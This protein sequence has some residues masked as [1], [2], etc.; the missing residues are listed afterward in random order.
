QL[1]ELFTLCDEEAQRTAFIDNLLTAVDPEVAGPT[2]VVITLRADFYPHCAAYP[3]LREALARNQEY[4]GPMNTSELRRAIEEPALRGGWKFQSGLVDLMLRDVR[5][6]PGALPLLSHALLETWKRRSRRT[7]TLRGYAEAG[8]VRRAIARSAEQVYHQELSEEQRGIAR[9]VFLRLTELGEGTEDTRRRVTRTELIPDLGQNG[10]TEGVLATLAEA[11]L[12]TLSEEHVEVAH[13]ALIREWPRLREWLDEDR[14]GLRIHR[15]L[16]E[17]AQAWEA[18]GRDPGELYRGSRLAQVSEWAEKQKEELNPLERSFLDASKDESDRREKEREARRRRTIAG[19]AAGMVI[20]L[21][22]ALLAGLQWQR[23]EVEE[24]E[25][26]QQASILLA[27]QA[28]T[29]LENGY[30]DRAV[31]LALEALENYPYTPQA[32]KALGQAVSYNRALQHYSGH[33]S[34]VTS[35]A[36]SPDGTRIAS[37]STDNTVHIWDASTGEDLLVIDLPQ[38]ITGNIFDMALTVKWSPDGE[39]LLIVTGDRFTLGSQDFDI[40]LWDATSGEQIMSFEIANRAEPEAG[41]GIPT[42]FG[43]FTTAAAAD[44]APLSGRLATLGG[45]N[46]T[47]VWDA[48]LQ[49]QEL[50]LVGHEN[51]VNGVDWSP[52]EQRLATASEDGTV[53]IW[54]SQ[55]GVE[56]TLLTGHEGAVNAVVWSPDGTQLGTGG[57]DGTVLFWDAETGKLLQN[58]ESTGGIV[59]SLAWSMD[60]SHLAIGTDDAFIRIWDVASGMVVTEFRGHSAFVSHVAWSPIGDKL[61][62]AGADG[63]ARIW[64]TAMGT[65]ATTLPYHF[66]SDFSWSSDGRYLA[67]PIG[68]WIFGTDPGK[69]VVWDVNN[70]HL[71]AEELVTEFIYYWAE[72]KFSPDDRFILARGGPG[73]GMDVSGLETIHAIDVLTGET[74]ASF[75]ATDG[76]W[77]RDHDWSP[78][79]RL[80][81]GATIIGTIYIWDFQT[82]DLL[83]TMIHGDQAF[84][85]EVEWSPDGTKLASAAAD[86]IIWV[87][88]AAKGEELFSLVGHE[89]PA[90]IMSVTW[91]P[92]GNQILTTSGNPDLGAKD[93]TVRIWDGNSGEELLVIDGHSGYVAWGDW[94]P[95]SGR[96]VTISKDNTTRIWDA[97]SGAELLVLSTPILY[98]GYLEWSPDGNFLAVGGDTGAPMEI[99]RVWQSTEELIAY[100]KE[101]C[102]IR[103]LTDTEREMF[104]LP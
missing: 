92:D 99:W 17:A 40:M 39:N 1:E 33:E 13:E 22:L 74:V 59:W 83:N 70:M 9:N 28:E 75:T 30:T 8:G 35:V 14:E 24:H 47:I 103:E 98:V 34:A 65:A 88:D 81:A 10:R 25:A 53:R 101:C 32:E 76:S 43:H 52:D 61:A 12:I 64:N 37:S 44:F 67:L 102:V 82:G 2:V 5:G 90:E 72:V 29:E 69:L 85:N 93:N 56:L 97:T 55:T 46:S 60:G 87:W 73:T 66:L 49:K 41:E 89:P 71:E 50:V 86:S 7:L 48:S 38:G 62:S 19:L 36:W 16:T 58:I 21:V 96:I 77:I 68:D 4:I 15:H 23:A 104:G 94:S 63:I 57:D 6:E 31:L 78:D 26:S 95:N 100:A 80:V 27:A 42:W 84:V 45:D 54:D 3:A 20:A 91:S 11:R 79:G 51:D 18:L